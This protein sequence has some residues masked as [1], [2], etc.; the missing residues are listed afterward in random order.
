MHL[1]CHRCSITPPV[2]SIYLIISHAPSLS[3]LLH[4]TSCMLH[5]PNYIACT[6]TVTVA[7]P[8]LLYAPYTQ[9]YCMHL[10][11]HSCSITHPVCSI[12]LIISHAPSQSQLLHHTSC[13]LHIRNYITCTFTVTVA[14]SH[15]LHAPYT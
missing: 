12:Y 1:H 9:L 2:C 4:H 3:Q 14:P 10:H 15:L 7:P 13:M 8:H 11:S 5:I 6:F